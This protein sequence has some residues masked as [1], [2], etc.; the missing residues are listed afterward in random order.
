MPLHFI[1]LADAVVESDSQF[2]THQEET[3]APCLAQGHN[4]KSRE[5]NPAKA[6]FIT[7]QEVNESP[8][9]HALMF[10]LFHF[11]WRL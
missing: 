7:D 8:A 9:Y 2:Y 1:Q 11:N 10:A 5:L 3:G 6:G 4:R